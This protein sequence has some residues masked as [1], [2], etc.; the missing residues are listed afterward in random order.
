MLKRE[1]KI[2]GYKYILYEIFVVTKV[3]FFLWVCHTFYINPFGPEK[4]K[5]IDVW[6]NNM[7][8]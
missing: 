8:P 4:A 7:V 6:F 5:N 1:A 3:R 2:C